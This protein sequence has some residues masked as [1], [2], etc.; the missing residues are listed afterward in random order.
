M[1]KVILILIVLMIIIVPFLMNGSLGEKTI[2]IQDID[3]HNIISIENNLKQI[4]KVGDLGEEEVKKILLSLPDL[5]WDKLNRYGRR[6]KRDLVNWLRERDIDDVDEI[7]ALIRIL[8]KFKAY[9]NELLTRKLANIFIEDKETFIK[10][11]ALNKGNLLEL[12]YAFFYLELYGEEGGR[13]LT[14]DFNDILN[15]ERLTKEEKLV[16]FEFLEIIASC[17]T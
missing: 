14:D 13:Y 1:K 9:D 10:A 15:S 17:E 3:F 12:G 7:S 5:D 8:N 16:G 11:L 4:I 2:N 6:F